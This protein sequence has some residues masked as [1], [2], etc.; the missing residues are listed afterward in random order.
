VIGMNPT[1]MKAIVNTGPGKLK[2]LNHPLPQTGTGWVR[3]RT[4]F[5][6]ICSTDIKMIAGWKRT[7]FP[8]IPGHEWAGIVDAVGAGVNPALIGRLCVADNIIA[9]SE[10]GF[11]YPGGYAQ[12]FLTRAENLY[13]LPDRFPAHHAPL[14]E[15]LAVCL[16]A[17]DRQKIEKD[18]PVL[19]FGDGPIGL[20]LLA[21]LRQRGVKT[22]WL[23]GGLSSRMALAREIGA[24]QVIDYHAFTPDSFASLAKS[25]NA[26]FP[27]IIE[28]SGSPAALDWAFELAPHRGRILILGD[29]DDAR[30]NFRWTDLLHREIE[31]GGSNASAGAWLAAVRL[32]LDGNLPLE[33]LITHRLPYTEFAQAVEITANHKESCIKVLLDWSPK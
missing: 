16:H 32:A 18:C 25:L 31:I 22:T 4:R 17:L 13:P 30:A 1:E 7:P 14:I 3:I 24:S 2:L 6:G 33:K 10:V 27:L 11:E 8:A 9:G 26:G 5:V 23:V 20:L 28:A 12:Y 21:V 19:L 29:Y 15:P